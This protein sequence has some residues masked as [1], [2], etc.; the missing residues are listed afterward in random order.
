MRDGN[1]TGSSD[2]MEVIQGIEPIPPKEGHMRVARSWS[3]RRWRA[4]GAAAVSAVFVMALTAGS[5]ARA[6]IPASGGTSPAATAM[7][8]DRYMVP[9]AQVAALETARTELEVSCLR[10]LGIRPDANVAAVQP[11]ASY[12]VF[13]PLSSSQ[14]ADGYRA[15]ATPGL[16]A[17]GYTEAD[18]PALVEGTLPQHRVTKL[19][20]IPA[21]RDELTALF[22]ASMRI[23]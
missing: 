4:V 23:W 21:G 6:A 20:P 3:A 15:L 7:P 17:V 9:D 5:P 1:T 2:T 13:S 19:S 11:T 16:E 22:R 8:L 12:P 14:A 18:I 10:S